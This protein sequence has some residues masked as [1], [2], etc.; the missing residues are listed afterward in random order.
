[1]GLCLGQKSRVGASDDAYILL[2]SGTLSLFE[3]P[4]NV[5]ITPM[6]S[7]ITI[8]FLPVLGA[9]GFTE[10]EEYKEQLRVRNLAMVL[11]CIQARQVGYN[12]PHSIMVPPKCPFFVDFK[13]LPSV[14]LVFL[15]SHNNL[16]HSS[17]PLGTT[18]RYTNST[19]R[20]SLTAN[21][22]F[23]RRNSDFEWLECIYIRAQRAINDA[24]VEVKSVENGIGVVRLIS[25]FSEYWFMTVDV[26]GEVIKSVRPRRP[27]PGTPRIE[28]PLHEVEDLSQVD[29]YST[30][31]QDA[32]SQIT[33]RLPS[34]RLSPVPLDH[35]AKEH[36]LINHLQ[37][38][39]SMPH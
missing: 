6:G 13:Y 5:T 2:A 8:V 39:L 20:S 19:L 23:G 4:S 25:S 3:E 18:T 9:S 35:T 32:V 11:S 14:L 29:L 17:S 7:T 12:D 22:M 38:C 21:E 24:Y 37:L 33:L 10:G 28:M 15:V 27:P 16:A 1:M 36:Q 34:L 26:V 30:P 31:I